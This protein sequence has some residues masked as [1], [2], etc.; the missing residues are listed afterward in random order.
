MY[1]DSHCH[2][3]D[4]EQARKETIAHGLKV[5]CDSG[6]DVVID[7]P[8]TERPVVNR[9]RVLE[10]FKLALE[11]D[12]PV[13]YGTY[14]GLTSDS[15]QICEAVE[16][17]REFAYSPGRKVFVAGIKAFWGKSVGSLSII[18]PEQQRRAISKLSELKFT[19]VLAG[20]YERESS[21][22]PELF[23][24]SKP[25]TWN[26]ARPEEAEVFSLQEIVTFAMIHHF[27]GHLH[28]C[29]VS[30]PE[31]VQLVSDYKTHMRMSCEVTP[32]HLLLDTG[33][34][35]DRDGILYK[36]NP[37][38]RSPETRAELF[39]LFLRGKIDTL[40]TDH[41]PHTSAEKRNAPYMSGIP[42]LASW[43]DF[44]KLLAEAGASHLIT[45]MAF[46]NPCKI[47]NLN[48]TMTN[49]GSRSRVSDYVF[50]PYSHFKK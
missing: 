50:N 14:I 19:G 29:H 15:E 4:E 45:R 27:K 2:F 39:D 28:V 48:A 30:V 38:L 37:P 17:C 41:A 12:S 40:A 49:H 1:I 9:A 32:H 18:N 22:K 43:P 44:T 34:M 16:T 31:S 3:R 35:Q 7:M 46:D 21:L 10:R 47:F 25:E 33:V 20:H 36:V 42:G 5:A 24:S 11:S 13:V 8:N 23:D 6:L 26:D